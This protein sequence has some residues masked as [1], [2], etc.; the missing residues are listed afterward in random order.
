[1]KTLAETRLPS[2]KDKLLAGVKLNKK[3]TKVEEV[4]SKL[5]RKLSK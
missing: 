4:I 2:L 1:M 3:P 5:K